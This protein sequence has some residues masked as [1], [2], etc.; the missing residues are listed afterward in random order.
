VEGRDSKDGLVNAGDKIWI[1]KKGSNDKF[2]IISVDSQQARD[3][4]ARSKDIEIARLKVM[5]ADDT[6]GAKRRYPPTTEDTKNALFG[7][8]EL[9]IEEFETIA[10]GLKIA[11]PFNKGTVTADSVF[12]VKDAKGDVYPFSCNSE[13]GRKI[14]A[15]ALQNRVN[16]VGG[17]HKGDE[18]MGK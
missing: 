16:N 8:I 15:K 5:L 1:R 14:F 6:T 9:T 2:N 3:I 17:L 12:L 13:E 18:V 10:E 11:P 7:S 4:I